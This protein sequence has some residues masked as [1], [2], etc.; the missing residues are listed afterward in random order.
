MIDSVICYHIKPP[1]FRKILGFFSTKVLSCLETVIAVIECLSHRSIRVSTCLTMLPCFT[2]Y[3]TNLH[4]H[5]WQL[6]CITTATR[7]LNA[8]YVYIPLF[9]K[10]KFVVNFLVFR[11]FYNMY[12]VKKFEIVFFPSMSRTILYVHVYII[13]EFTITY[14]NV[15]FICLSECACLHKTVNMVFFLNYE[16]TSPKGRVIM[17]MYRVVSI[18]KR[19]YTYLAAFNNKY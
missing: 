10:L 12:I 13:L 16:Y 11:D 3:V 14:I 7:D 17:Q 18:T 15:S 6:W 4:F 1:T 8:L 19:G 5:L 2:Y 9:G